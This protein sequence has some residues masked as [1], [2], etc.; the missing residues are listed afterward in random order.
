MKI[1]SFPPIEPAEPKVLILGTMPSKKSLELNQYYGHGGNQFWRILFDLFQVEFSSNYQSRVD[2][3]LRNQIAIWDVL[4]ACERESSADSDILFEEPNDFQSFFSKHKTIRAVFFNGKAAANYFQNDFGVI[5]IYHF[6]LPSTSP[7]NTWFTY[8][9]RFDEWKEI[10][11][12][13]K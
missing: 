9:T 12:W 6:T 7:A 10:L 5:D 13:T 11:N 8:S 1:Y 3:A 2:L 4:K